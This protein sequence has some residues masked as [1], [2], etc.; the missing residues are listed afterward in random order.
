MD[1]PNVGEWA[2]DGSHRDAIHVAVAPV[3][4]AHMLIRGDRVALNAS[5][6][7]YKT[8]RVQESIGVVDP[9]LTVAVPL[10]VTFWLFLNPGTVTSLRHV[11]THPGFVAKKLEDIK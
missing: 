6:E 4:A 8:A 5:G 9:F 3:R 11:W 1:A 10:G 2:K 7:A